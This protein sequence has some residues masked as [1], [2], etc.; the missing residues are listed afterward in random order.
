VNAFQPE[1]FFDL[2]K[3][4]HEHIFNNCQSVWEVLPQI[5]DYLQSNSLGSI[6]TD[7]PDGVV[8]INKE[9]ISIGKGTVVEPGA[10]IKGP[11]IIGENCQIRQGAYIRGNVICGNN[12]VIGHA[13][14]V[15]NVLFLDHA[16][17]A[18]FAYVG[19]SVLGNHTNLGAGTKCANLRFDNGPVSVHHDGR[20]VNTQLRK[21][22]AVFGDL[23]QSGCNS[24][25]S[26]GTLLGKGASIY[27]CANAR[28]F[29]PDGHSFKQNGKIVE[30]SLT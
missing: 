10:Y 21:F 8:L 23:S 25:T 18:H 4:A 1:N 6:E 16:Q 28:G 5:K 13:T 15:K 24:V 12:C 17:A 29:I 30:L 11:C 22:G 26:P 19:D 2:S 27:P 14:E 9:L 7:I 20:K 3:F